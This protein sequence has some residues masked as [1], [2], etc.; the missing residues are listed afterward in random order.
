MPVEV[1]TIEQLDFFKDLSYAEQEQIASCLN[2]RI[3]TK[4]DVLLR[5]GT[6]ALTFFI[7]LSGTFKVILTEG[8]SYSLDR[9]GTIIG[10]STVIAPFEYTGTAV[11]E[12]DG[13]VLYISSHEFFR[14]IQNNNALG[15][16]I[17]KRI[18][19]IASVRRAFASN[20]ITET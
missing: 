3:I 5:R 11:A 6:P 15:E 16:K 8:R 7:I 9:K 13:N 19:E 18:N 2:P 20:D 1:K 4:G 14:L 12:T 17:M 10:W